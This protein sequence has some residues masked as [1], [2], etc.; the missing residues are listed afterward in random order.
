MINNT[1]M[2]HRHLQRYNYYISKHNAL[3]MCLKVLPI[4]IL[5][6]KVL[7]VSFSQM[8]FLYT[9][10]ITIEREMHGTDSTCY[11]IKVAHTAV[12]P[13]LTKIDL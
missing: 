5:V 12:R 4:L 2:K 6:Q 8:T 1:E 10:F 9:V 3:K 11:D 13:S 7:S